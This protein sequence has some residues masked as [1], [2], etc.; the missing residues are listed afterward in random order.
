MTELS[1]SVFAADIM[2]MKQDLLVLNSSN[3]DSLHIDIMDGH[4][5]PLFGFNSI[6]IKKISEVALKPMV[7][8]FMAYLTEDMLNEYL[9]LKPKVIIIH[10]EAHPYEAN[11][12]FFRKI[13][14]N[15]IDCGMAISPKIQINTLFDYLD[16]IDQ[17]LIMSS[18][19]GRE[20]S[21]FL[22]NTFLRIQEIDEMLRKKGKSI[23]ISV[24]G[25]LNEEL[26]KQCIDNG[27]DKIIIGRAFYKEKNKT[28]LIDRI[29]NYQYQK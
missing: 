22:D 10:T 26:A 4:F 2:R 28:A 20:N 15:G 29:H 25:G 11:I 3:V 13:K 5:V 6:W 24:D 1:I 9:K 16:L 17:I 18:E 12:E 21:S 27:A 8:H 23:R 14:E 19:P 7:F